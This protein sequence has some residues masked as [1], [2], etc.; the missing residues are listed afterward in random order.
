M[1]FGR[2]EEATCPACGHHVAVAFY[3]GGDQPLATIA[4]PESA[5]RAQTM[6]RLSLDFVRCVNC[7]HVYNQAFDY[8]DVPYSE[9]PNLMFNRGTHWSAF[10]EGQQR[11][12][13]SDLPDR[14][15]VI[16]VGHGDG[17]FLAALHEKRPEGRYIGFDPHGA[18]QGH[19][20]IV[21]RQELFEP[22]L[23]LEELHPNLIITR[24]VLE[25]LTN[26]LGLLQ[27]TSFAAALLNLSPLVYIEV[28]CIDAAIRNRRTV[29]FYYEH[30]SQF[31][32]RSFT[33]ML[34]KAADEIIEVGH[35]YDGEV[36]YGFARLGTTISSVRIANEA[37]G[38]DLDSQTALKEISAQ[39][40]ALAAK[41]DPVAVWGGTGKS[42]AFMCRYGMDTERFP[43]VVDSDVA[44]VG[45]FVP[46][47]GQEIRFRDWLLSYP[48]K[49]IVIPPQWRAK[50]ISREM[51]DV[52]ISAEQVLIEHKGRLIDFF[53]DPH[54][55][56]T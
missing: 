20:H 4:W 25:H 26:P 12:I 44:K 43:L 28:P 34:E 8:A 53:K 13:L 15:V 49:T 36:V 52:G 55:Y 41:G 38:F 10:L 46:G 11:A 48:V 1:G 37:R 45:T 56:A 35:G 17:S 50:D 54:P 14:P 3:D 32:T 30:S 31:T 9:K 40:A 42:A 51:A 16:E 39:L 47:T 29:D 27:R 5:V 2:L 19:N 21:F 7:G 23:H 6:P 33:T 18:S 22:S 24:H